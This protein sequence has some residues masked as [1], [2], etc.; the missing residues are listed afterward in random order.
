VT[1]VGSTL[2][3]PYDLYVADDGTAT[4][5]VESGGSVVSDRYAYIARYPRANGTATVAGAGSV[6]NNADVL[7]IAQSGTG[8]LRVENGGHVFVGDD[9][10]MQSAGGTAS[11][12][13]LL[14]S[15]SDPLID[16]LDEATL[17]GTLQVAMSQSASLTPADA[18]T[19]IDIAGTRTGSFDNHDES[20]LLGTF[21]GVNL[22]L[23]YL[24][25]DGN[26]VVAYALTPGDTDGDG[27]I[28]DADLGVAFA[29]YTGPL[30]A[31]EGTKT[32][33]E[34]DT[35]GDGDV[36]DADLGNAFANYTGPL[37][38]A[39]VPEPASLALTGLGVLALSRRRASRCVGCPT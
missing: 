30:A 39:S 11:L 35:D 5:V 26:D 13:F 4:L 20:S 1:G 7:S 9:L 29:D 19:L 16:V 8:E 10:F 6:W 17:A 2:T 24:G 37:A 15:P 18:F 27:D 34:G 22:Y 36:D 23:T 14:A 3:S 21:D 38:N 25:G 33:A 12:R 32:F 28:D 31:G